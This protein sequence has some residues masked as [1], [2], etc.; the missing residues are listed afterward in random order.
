MFYTI[1]LHVEKKQKEKLKDP[2][3][4]QFPNKTLTY[5]FY[6]DKIAKMTIKAIKV[7]M[8]IEILCNCDHHLDTGI[9]YVMCNDLHIKE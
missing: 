8:E 1:A 3:R 9:T 6:V 2:K 7:L 5:K 4:S